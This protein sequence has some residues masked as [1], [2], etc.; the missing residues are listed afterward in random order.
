M[1]RSKG[2]FLSCKQL[3]GFTP[4]SPFLEFIGLEAGKETL[5]RHNLIARRRH[6]AVQFFVALG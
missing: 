4:V 6:H 3:K 2:H 5:S 1:R